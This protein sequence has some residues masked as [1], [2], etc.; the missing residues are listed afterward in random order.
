[1]DLL[2]LDIVQQYG[3]YQW[4][5]SFIFLGLISL[6]RQLSCPDPIPYTSL[7]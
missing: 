3:R 7:F 5:L 1:M 2:W 4:I 6:D